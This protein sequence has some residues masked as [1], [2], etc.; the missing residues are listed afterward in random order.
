MAAAAVLVPPSPHNVYSSMAT[1]TR[2][3]PLMS[4]PNATNSPHRNLNNSGSKRTRAFANIPQQEN[5]PPTKR[6][7]IE[8]S[9]REP[10]PI[11][12]RRHV[13]QDGHA[14]QVFERGHADPENTFQKR[15]VAARD[16]GKLTVPARTTRS[17]NT[18]T[19]D[20]ESVRQWQKHYRRLFPG[21]RF[22]FDAVSDD[23]KQKLV[24]QAGHF[25]AREE[26]FFCVNVTHIITTRTIPDEDVVIGALD[27]GHP[28]INPSVLAF[29]NGQGKREMHNRN[30]VLI[31]G[32]KH[33]MKIWPTE[34]LQKML[35]TLEDEPGQEQ[36]S[37]V[38]KATK[39]T[40]ELVQ[41]LRNEKLAADAERE[42]AGAPRQLQPFRGPY[43]YV[44]DMDEKVKPIMVREYPKVARRQDGEWPQFRSASVGKCPFVEDHTSKRE[45]ERERTQAK[46]LLLKQQG[47]IE[48]VAAQAKSASTSQTLVEPRME[49]PQRRSPRKALREVASNAQSV[50]HEPTKPAQPRQPER[51]SSFPPMPEQPSIEFVRPSQLHLIREPSASGIVRST[52]T[53]AIQS[54]MISSAAAT[55]LKASTSREVNELKRKVLEKTH[56]GSLSVG[57]ISSSQQVGALTSVLR[58][59]RPPAPQRAAKSRAQEKLG[60]IQEEIDPYADDIVAQRAIQA[61]T[62]RRKPAKREAKPGYC[63]NCHDKYDDFEDVSPSPENQGLQLTFFSKSFRVSTAN[64]P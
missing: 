14:G 7:A 59:A 45:A 35:N 24:R 57:S 55:G 56:T 32:L 47:E 25:G 53:S 61:A 21:F 48:A 31:Q 4:I 15:L 60:G 37:R 3:Q 46:A 58:N 52:M 11:T 40:N 20:V 23:Q 22:Y 44:H 43:I 16:R 10:V 36:T 18:S 29:R 8:K 42:Y 34:K 30:D 5:E 13:G 19:K 2:R 17:N 50:H 33:G 12:P 38:S 1:S 28:T 54:Q 51:Q 62:K 39:V 9:N 41:V 26:T 27:D 49:P 64:L 6:Q 63:E